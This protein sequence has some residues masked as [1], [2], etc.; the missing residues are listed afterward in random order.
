MLVSVH[1]G[2]STTGLLLEALPQVGGWLVRAS[3]VDAA[4]F[5]KNP[6]RTSKTGHAPRWAASM[7][8]GGGAVLEALLCPAGPMS[9]RPKHQMPGGAGTCAGLGAPQNSC[10]MSCAQLPLG[11]AP[12]S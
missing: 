3:S 12:C 9:A 4:Q 8:H 7:S 10:G 6:L 1:H 5:H 2:M 11:S